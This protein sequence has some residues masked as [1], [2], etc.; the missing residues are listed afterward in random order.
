VRRQGSGKQIESG[1]QKRQGTEQKQKRKKWKSGTEGETW[2][3]NKKVAG[4]NN[5]SS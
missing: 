1:Q 4:E 5:S 2:Q 3:K